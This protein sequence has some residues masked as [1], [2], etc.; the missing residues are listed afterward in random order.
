MFGPILDGILAGRRFEDGDE[1]DMGLLSTANGS[2]AA[3]ACGLEC[4]DQSD[5]DVGPSSKGPYLL[6]PNRGMA[7]AALMPHYLTLT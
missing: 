4:H 7:P 3:Q 6:L 2:I 5:R 1:A